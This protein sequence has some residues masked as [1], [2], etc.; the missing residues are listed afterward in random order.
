MILRV[1]IR[2]HMEPREK[3]AAATNKKEEKERR[4]N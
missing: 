4:I 1:Y 2:I 3:K